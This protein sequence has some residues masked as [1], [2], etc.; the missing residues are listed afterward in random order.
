[1]ISSWR[2]DSL[3]QANRASV[4]WWSTRLGRVGPHVIDAG[5]AVA[6]AVAVSIVISVTRSL[7]TRPPD[8]LAYV[9]AVTIGAAWYW[10]IP[11]LVATFGLF[12]PLAGTLNDL[13]RDGSIMAAVLLLLIQPPQEEAPLLA[14]WKCLGALPVSRRGGDRLLHLFDKALRGINRLE[15]TCNS[16]RAAQMRHCVRLGEQCLQQRRA[17]FL[18]QL[19]FGRIAHQA[20]ANREAQAPWAARKVFVCAN[21]AEV[22]SALSRIGV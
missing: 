11:L 12:E 3:Q 6:V 13:V 14:P 5:L 22:H 21:A 7:G 9:L 4:A 19:Y 20:A 1:M 16:L 18:Q 8:A 2:R 10:V 15:W 17:I